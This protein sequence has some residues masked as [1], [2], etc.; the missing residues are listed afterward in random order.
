MK[1]TTI[2]FSFD[3]AKLEA[4]TLFLKEKETTLGEELEHFMESLY[5]KYVPQ[6]VRE[7][8]E[9][10]EAEDAKTAP[11]QRPSRKKPSADRNAVLDGD[12]VGRE[13]PE[14]T[15]KSPCKRFLRACGAFETATPK[16]RQFG[17]ISEAF[18]R[19]SGRTYFEAG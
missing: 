15:K 4:I 10:K 2:E 14:R 18:T 16:H 8:I 12:T 9:K 1:P 11:Q 17:R 3:D 6:A 7:F 19:I 13:Q 5:K